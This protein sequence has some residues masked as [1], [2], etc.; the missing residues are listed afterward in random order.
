MLSI[1]EFSRGNCECVFIRVPFKIKEETLVPSL[2]N[3]AEFAVML[4]CI[5]IVFVSGVNF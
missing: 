3:P 4:T 2:A 1:S 5:E